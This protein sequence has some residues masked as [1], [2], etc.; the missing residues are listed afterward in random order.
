[1]QG[2]P[3]TPFFLPAE[4]GQ[5]Y[6]LYQAAATGA[7]AVLFVHPFAEEL[8]RSRRMAALQA[9]AF[10]HCGIASLRI[11]LHG[12]GDS[13]GDFSDARWETWIADLHGALHWL[14]ERGHERITLLGLRLGGLLALEVARQPALDIEKLI[15]WQMPASGQHALTQWLRL[16]SANAMLGDSEGREGTQALRQHLSQGE[17]IE[18][19]GYGLAPAMA[20]AIDR[21]QPLPAPCPAT[22]IDIVQAPTT[23][24]LPATARACATWQHARLTAVSGPAFWSSAEITVSDAL[25]AATCKEMGA[26]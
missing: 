6:C 2:E 17:I 7:P 14:R 25:V 18:V 15:L 20:A 13:S 3:A 1:M 4:G 19:G 9:R 23:Q 10:A 21:V 5:R 16:R 11:D 26:A 12:C 24:V 8:N 22:V